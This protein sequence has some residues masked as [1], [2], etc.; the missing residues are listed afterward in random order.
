M[1]SM[2]DRCEGNG[3]KKEGKERGQKRQKRK[4]SQKQLGWLQREC[5][6][7]DVKSLVIE[8]HCGH[9]LCYGD[10]GVKVSIQAAAGAIRQVEVKVLRFRK[11]GDVCGGA[12]EVAHKE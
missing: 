2:A 4:G 5:C 12:A 1:I 9:G 11:L 3:R 8:K 7:G 6:R 10:G